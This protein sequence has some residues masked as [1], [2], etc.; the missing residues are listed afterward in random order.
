MVISHFRRS[1]HFFDAAFN[2]AWTRTVYVLLSD[3]SLREN[4]LAFIT[5]EAQCAGLPLVSILWYKRIIYYVLNQGPQSF[6]RSAAKRRWITNLLD[7]RHSGEA[8][9]LCFMGEYLMQRN[10]LIER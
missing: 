2:T 1:F 6:V 10:G 4:S 9:I 3:A 7:D 5:A 8:E